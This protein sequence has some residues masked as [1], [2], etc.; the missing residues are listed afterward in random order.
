ME[1]SKKRVGR[2][3][4][5][6]RKGK[7]STISVRLAPATKAR[8]NSAS[9]RSDRPLG[10]EAELRIEQSFRDDDLCDLVL[11]RQYG[12]QIAGLL[13]L[14]A[15]TAC[16]AVIHGRP[17]G[18]HNLGP[19]RDWMREPYAFDLVARNIGRLLEE[20]RPEGAPSPVGPE[21]S[22][23]RAVP[24][25]KPGTFDLV[26]EPGA[27]FAGKRWAEDVLHRARSPFPSRSATDQRLRRA[28]ERLGI[29]ESIDYDALKEARE[30]GEA[31]EAA[32]K[33]G[34]TGDER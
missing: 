2:P 18:E 13:T 8:L 9:E 26:E 31:L 4:A 28:G 23:Q 29:G 34:E 15:E 33:K 25:E 21:Q 16:W 10:Q 24:T 19:D 32:R 1:N 12:K 27:I 3:M 17:P 22:G 7:K 5:P 30:R 11:E 6:A 14:I 20:L